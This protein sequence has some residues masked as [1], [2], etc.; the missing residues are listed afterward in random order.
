MPPWVVAPRHKEVVN[1]FN[2][3]DDDFIL[4]PTNRKGKID[5]FLTCPFPEETHLPKLQ[6][7][8]RQLFLCAKKGLLEQL[9]QLHNFLRHYLSIL[10][11]QHYNNQLLLEVRLK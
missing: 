7:K 10:L 11:L 9:Y 5:L 3:S 6:H 8:R 1:L 4:S 2:A